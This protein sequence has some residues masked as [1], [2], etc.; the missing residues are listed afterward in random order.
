MYAGGGFF[1]LGNLVFL[2]THLRE[3]F[4]RTSSGSVIVY[5]VPSVMSLS[6]SVSSLSLPRFEVHTS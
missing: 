4:A 2:G 1:F 3:R 5:S 6:V